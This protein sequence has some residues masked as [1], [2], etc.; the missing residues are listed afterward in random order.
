MPSYA[1]WGKSDSI[2]SY[3]ILKTQ[4]STNLR[5]CHHHP[6]QLEVIGVRRKDVV[7]NPGVFLR[8]KNSLKNIEDEG[9]PLNNRQGKVHG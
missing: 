5:L 3:W 9:H 4:K 8:T 2:R 1:A 6:D 7:N